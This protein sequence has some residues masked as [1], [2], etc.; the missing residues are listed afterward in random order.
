MKKKIFGLTL[1]VVLAS[2]SMAGQGAGA[3]PSTDQPPPQV[4]FRAEVNYVEVDARV[5]DAQGKFV[6]GLAQGDF[7]IFEDGKPQP[8][9]VFNL[10]NLSVERQ[11]R[12]LFA[13]Q[14]IEA[15]VQT[16]ASGYTGRVYLIVLDDLHTTPLLAA[17]TRLA[18]RQFVERYVGS[19]DVAA[20]MHTSGRTGGGQEFTS[21]SRLLLS[22]IDKFS[23]RK[24]RSAL[25]G[26]LDQEQMTRGRR[27]AG[28]RIDDPDASE[29][30]YHA[31][32]TLDSLKNLAQI[33]EGVRGRRKALVYFSEGIDYDISDPFNNRDATS[34]IEATRDAIAA[35]TRANV[36]FYGVD[37]RGLGAGSDT[38]IDIQSFPEDTTL[39]L[40]SSALLREVRN[41][42]DSLRVLSEETGGFAVVNNNDIPGAFARLV[43]ENSSY[44]VLG[45]YPANDRRDGR[46]RKIEVRVKTPGLTVRA[47]RGYVAPRGRTPDSKL[48]GPN[49]ASAEL[50]EAM[51]SPVP[52]S[53]LPIAVTASVF[54]GP[55]NSGTVVVST[56]VGGR[57][58]VLVDK[59]GTFHNDLE[60]A[61]L[62]VDQK[63]KSFFGDRNTLNLALK[64]DT[65]ARLRAA[66][67]RVISSLD[68]PPG[69]YQLR[70]AAREA[71]TR[72]SGS[73]LYD[74]EVPDYAK[75][76]LSMSSL[77]LTSAATSL[78]PTARP[79]DPLQKL[80]PGPLT[81]YREFGQNDEI[82][83]FTEVYESGN[84]PAHKVE[85]NLAMKAEGGQTVFQT[86]E[87]RDSAELKGNSGGYGF[88][89]RIPLRDIAPG[90]YVLRVDAHARVGDRATAA[91]E[92]TIT[93]IGAPAPAAAVSASPRAPAGSGSQPV[94]P[95]S[96]AASVG[97]PASAASA[98]TPASP[99]AA[100]KTANAPTA[101]VQP[102]PMTTVNSD[103][104]SGID[105]PQ[106]T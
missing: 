95:A 81:S 33:M 96:P 54:K 2:A 66:G 88:S 92:T 31:R 86:R 45:Y 18:A 19:T 28:E 82:A 14:P 84:G 52:V 76:R 62:A 12:P 34:V 80:L 15:D 100:V 13:S 30:G 106:Q 91:R 36:A 77:A 32:N 46:F 23:G 83:L 40:D 105:R 25:L 26:R 39:G 63:G 70:V 61:W 51:S 38:G 20:V 55:D 24:L 11:A 56:L 7:E 6:T 64:P 57:D 89:A 73:V 85:I 104:M 58:L 47:R 74:I 98:R 87:E 75:E 48:A 97:Q 60:V 93:V 101:P 71:N 90:L 79:K 4:T 53:G 103:M 17:R 94:A 102:M 37:V 22:A 44:Y 78:A 50:R 99:P 3:Q 8:V 16:N 42:Q 72:R 10:V 68:L 5:L 29:R 41:G 35:A 59:G 43:E 67:F 65:V 21:N 9:S 27:G 49:D 69:R 1:G